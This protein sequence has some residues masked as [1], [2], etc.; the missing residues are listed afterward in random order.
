MEC[1]RFVSVV[2]L[3]VVGMVYVLFA[4]ADVLLRKLYV[5]NTDKTSWSVD[6]LSV[7]FCCASYFVTYVLSSILYVLYY[8][9]KRQHFRTFCQH[10]QLPPPA[11][12]KMCL[13]NVRISCFFKV[14]KCLFYK[15][16]EI[17][18]VLSTSNICHI[19]KVRNTIRFVD[20]KHLSA[21]PY[22]FF[23]RFVDICLRFV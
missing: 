12:I 2:L 4:Y 16:S 15:T 11:L 5:C 22:V 23:L 19:Q 3:C 18:Y 17:Q 8:R 6:V 7:L 10:L 20:V 9:W 21:F 14:A 1:R 13:Q